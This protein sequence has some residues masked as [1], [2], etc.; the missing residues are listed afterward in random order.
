VRSNDRRAHSAPGSG[1]RRCR[2]RRVATRATPSDLVSLSRRASAAANFYRRRR[3]PSAGRVTAP[4]HGEET[5]SSRRAKRRRTRVHYAGTSDYSRQQPAD[6]L[7][8]S[9]AKRASGRKDGLETDGRRSPVRLF[10]GPCRRPVSATL[11]DG[12]H[13]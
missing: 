5:L 1:R 11:A 3:S 4:T 6:G 2:P 13:E 7:E 9:P 12:R 10:A 8:R